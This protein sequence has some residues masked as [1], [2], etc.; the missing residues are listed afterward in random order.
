MDN[1][2]VFRLLPRFAHLKECKSHP[3]G[4]NGL[5]MIKDASIHAVKE[6]LGSSIMLESHPS[7]G[8]SSLI[9]PS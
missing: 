5:N 4:S 2:L 8:S 3:F 9:T 1:G 7:V 6:A